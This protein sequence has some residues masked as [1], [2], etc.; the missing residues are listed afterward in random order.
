MTA[1][2]LAVKMERM[3]FLRFMIQ[4]GYEA[5]QQSPGEWIDDSLDCL[6]RCTA[7]QGYT[8]LHYAAQTG[9]IAIFNYLMKT[10]DQCHNRDKQGQMSSRQMLEYQ[11]SDN[12][13]PLLIAA[14]HQRNDLFRTLI[15]DYSANLY[16]YDI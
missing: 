13:T 16:A 2:H 14:Q 10:Y 9:N 15:H 7:T 5:D 12:L 4:G 11:T 6:Y 8:P 3:P 1:V